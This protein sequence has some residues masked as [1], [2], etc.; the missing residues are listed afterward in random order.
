MKINSPPNYQRAYGSASSAGEIS[1]E[2]AARLLSLG[3]I[4]NRYARVWECQI[5][6][7]RKFYAQARGAMMPART[8][9]QKVSPDRCIKVCGDGIYVYLKDFDSGTT[10]KLT[11]DGKLLWSLEIPQG[12]PAVAKDSTMY[13]IGIRYLLSHDAAGNIRFQAPL[14]SL[15]ACEPVLDDGD[16][17]YIIKEDLKY[18]ELVCFDYKGSQRWSVKDSDFLRQSPFIDKGGRIHPQCRSSSD[19]T[20]PYKIIDP[21]KRN[22]WGKPTVS[23]KIIGY[24]NATQKPAADEN[25]NVYGIFNGKLRAISPEGRELWTKDSIDPGSDCTF[26][27]TGND[28]RIYT[29]IQKTKTFMSNDPATGNELWKLTGINIACP[30]VMIYPD[31]RTLVFEQEKNTLSLF[32]KGGHKIARQTAPVCIYEMKKAGGKIYLDSGSCVSVISEDLSGGIETINIRLNSDASFEPDG[33]NGVLVISG[34]KLIKFARL[35]DNQT[36]E[37]LRKDGGTAAVSRTIVR[38]KKTVSIGN[39]EIPVN[40][41]YAE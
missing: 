7:D 1:T 35:D 13:F 27:I 36:I 20:V 16:N 26:T 12:Q 32:D 29:Y 39:I 41:H 18:N 31:G 10:S 8:F 11:H 21:N 19:S 34:D 3:K 22:F 28:G 40:P 5:S 15:F 17:I 38:G 6:T 9:G 2:V 30:N 37:L 24:Y 33:S 25:G 4:K 23:V 14:M